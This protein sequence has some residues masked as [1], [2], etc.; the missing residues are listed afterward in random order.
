MRIAR[1]CQ[2]FVLQS[3]AMYSIVNA[4]PV[5]KFI[6]ID[7]FGYLTNSKKYAIIRDPQTG[8]DASDFFNPGSTFAVV[9]ATTGTQVLSAEPLSW[10]ANATDASSGDK[11]WW[12]DFSSVTVPG[13]YYVLDVSNNLRSFEFQIGDDV[14]TEVLKHAVRTFFYQRAGFEKASVYAGTQWEDGASHLKN[15]H[16]KNARQYNKLNDASTERDVSGG[17]YDAGDYNKYTN[18][19]AAYIIEFMRAFMENPGAW[20]DDYNIPESGNHIPD[21]LDEAKWGIDH[22]LRMQNSDGGVLS[23]VGLSHASPPSSATAPSLYGS[24]STSAT[25]NASGAY[26]L[27]A[28]V[29][30]SR[31]MNSYAQ[32]LEE[33]AI[34]A[35][36]WAL[37]NPAVIFKNN[38]SGSGTAGLGAGQQETD[39]YGRLMA[40]LKAAVFLFEITN[41]TKYRDFFD[42][43]YTQ[44]HL[45]QWSY[46]YPF[47][48]STQE[49]VL[50]Y[51]RSPTAT[52]A[53][54]NSI[55]NVY[56]TAMNNGAENFLAYY[57][58]KDPYR[59]H[60]KDYTWGSNST[61]ASQGLMFMDLITYDVDASKNDDARDA[62]EG[63]IHYLHGTNP[64]SFVYLSNMY[65]YGA[66]NGVNEFYH[67][68]FGD[69]SSRWDRV[70]VSTFGPAPGFVSGGPNPGYD[71]DGCCA[72]NTCGGTNNSLCN[73]ETLIP[74][75]GQPA[76]KSYKDFNT[77][78]PLNSWSV[79]E[80]SNGYQLNYIRLLSWVVMANRDCSGTSEGTASYDV[81]GQCT[82]GNTGQSP[83]INSSECA[84]ETV[85]GIEEGK[86]SNIFIAPNPTD[87]KLLLVTSTNDPYHVE[88]LNVQGKSIMS[89][90]AQGSESL[91][92]HMQPAGMY[93]VIISGRDNT[94]THVSKILKY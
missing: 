33:S 80:N 78:W 28:R 25:L 11:V 5:S 20:G 92:I 71:Y 59:A 85:T 44:A 35:W 9:D 61:K 58:F 23:I 94:W 93:F 63:Y 51:T 27:A 76:Q 10:K 40:K 22:L 7:Q 50:H 41:D 56:K 67:T 19:T 37:A 12:F 70:G 66:E 24:A 69:G 81:C 68:W 88:V 1:L 65:A 15:L 57:S 91:D 31:G 6:V 36:D 84:D 4:Q 18:W 72:T 8:F 43:N 64:L 73:S 2:I 82:G 3:L 38:D 62:A 49:T 46:A 26:A 87:G 55:L 14:Y 75:K 86:G 21:I 39:D 54:V 74:P 13:K 77:S 60:I 45:M 53:V 16:D 30:K 42:A 29:F 83:K 47:E 17:W 32:R 52:P 90:D 79:T 48:G 89:V 34:K